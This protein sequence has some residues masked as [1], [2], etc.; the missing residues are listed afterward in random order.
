M[1]ILLRKVKKLIQSQIRNR[2]LIKVWL[3]SSCSCYFRKLLNNKWIK[4]FLSLYWEYSVIQSL[5]LKLLKNGCNKIHLADFSKFSSDCLRSRISLFVNVVVDFKFN[6]SSKTTPPP[7]P[8]TSPQ[9]LLPP[10]PHLPT[11][12]AKFN[13][14]LALCL[15]ALKY[16]Q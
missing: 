13:S 2:G 9:P 16:W 11:S 7:A 4:L 14:T 5:K 12:G 1:V 10:P 6:L 15:R 8:T 3:W